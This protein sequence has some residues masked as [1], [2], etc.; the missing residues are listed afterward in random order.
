LRPTLKLYLKER[1]VYRRPASVHRTHRRSVN[2]VQR[3]PSLP[4]LCFG[5]SL[6]PRSAALRSVASPCAPLHCALGRC[7]QADAY[8]AYGPSAAATSVENVQASNLQPESA[9]ADHP[10]STTR[11]QV[12]ASNSCVGASGRQVVRSVVVGAGWKAV[13]DSDLQSVS[14]PAQ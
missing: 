12:A 6:L 4:A 9:N 10:A 1:C 14:D 8:W 5:R 3:D 7:W 13:I 11:R 2:R